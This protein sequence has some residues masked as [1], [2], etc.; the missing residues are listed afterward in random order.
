MGF[1]GSR[2]QIPP[3]RFKQLLKQRLAAAVIAASRFVK[4]Y[5]TSEPT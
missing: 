2:V 3:S 5:T 1:R 4:P